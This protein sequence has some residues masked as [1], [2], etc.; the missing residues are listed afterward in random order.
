MVCVTL[1]VE[2]GRDRVI[3]SGGTPPS[4]A[5]AP[6]GVGKVAHQSPPVGNKADTLP[7]SSAPSGPGSST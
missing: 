6:F 7:H 3:R 1:R 5:L 2:Q 4:R